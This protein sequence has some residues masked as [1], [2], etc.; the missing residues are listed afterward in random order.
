MKDRSN[1]RTL[2]SVHDTAHF[3][4]GVA[5][6]LLIG[7]GFSSKPNTHHDERVSDDL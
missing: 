4:L 6:R 3:K 7:Y 1:I 5:S 2:K